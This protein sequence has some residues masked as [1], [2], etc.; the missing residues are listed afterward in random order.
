MQIC[1]QCTDS[2]GCAAAVV[3]GTVDTASEHQT[4]SHQHSS[5]ATAKG[6]TQQLN[7]Y[8]WPALMEYVPCSPRWALPGGWLTTAASVRLSRDMPAIHL[9]SSRLAHFAPVYK[10]K[11]TLPPALEPLSAASLAAH[12]QRCVL[13]GLFLAPLHSCR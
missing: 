6:G 9:V 1:C 5:P 13:T 2:S 10:G 3:H 4:P 12:L 8:P 11:E 7:S